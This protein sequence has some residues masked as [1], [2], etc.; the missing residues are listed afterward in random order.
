M[1]KQSLLKLTATALAAA[2]LCACMPGLGELGS[3]PTV[4]QDVINVTGEDAVSAVLAA[5]N[6]PYEIFGLDAAKAEDGSVAT[7]N[8]AAANGEVFPPAATDMTPQEAA[9]TAAAMAELLGGTR[10]EE[11]SW[12]VWYFPAELQGAEDVN[13]GRSAYLCRV[14]EQGHLEQ[15]S[16]NICRLS[17]VVDGIT[18]KLVYG[19]VFPL[20]GPW[21]LCLKYDAAEGDEAKQAEIEKTY[22]EQAAAANEWI[23]SE[24]ALTETNALLAE[25]GITLEGLERADENRLPETWE[26]L[27]EEESG[28]ISLGG[29]YARLIGVRADDG[30]T[31]SCEVCIYNH[32]LSMVQ[33]AG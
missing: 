16:G 10:A 21:A 15:G 4:E 26:A 2:A 13:G 19:E 18:G 27:L 7:W 8:I 12:R 3:E 14:M 5:Y 22:A 9:N 24:A 28:R 23:A 31:V 33:M 29:P 30:R 25:L 11:E 20:D 6:E 17:F 1:E 32:K